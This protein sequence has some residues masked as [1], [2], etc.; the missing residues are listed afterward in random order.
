MEAGQG[1]RHMYERNKV[2]KEEG[3]VQSTALLM[4][5][6]MGQK[7]KQPFD[8]AEHRGLSLT[9][10]YLTLSSLTQAFIIISSVHEYRH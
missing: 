2:G 5:M 8:G 4:E 3:E 9:S 6:T 1:G 10:L 7:T